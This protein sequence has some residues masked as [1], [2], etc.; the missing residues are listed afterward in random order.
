MYSSWLEKRCV[1]RAPKLGEPPSQGSAAVNYPSLQRVGPRG[2][3]AWDRQLRTRGIR[4]DVGDDLVV[5][6]DFSSTVVTLNND[7]GDGTGE[8]IGVRWA[9]FFLWHGPAA[10]GMR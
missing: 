1:Q 4:G 8:K 2:D 5:D 9:R 7:H 3:H 10:N 6:E